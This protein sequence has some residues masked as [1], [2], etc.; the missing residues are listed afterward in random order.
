MKGKTL[1][2]QLSSQTLFTLKIFVNQLVPKCY[3]H[4]QFSSASTYRQMTLFR[5]RETHG[6]RVIMAFYERT[7]PTWQKRKFL[8]EFV[9]V[10]LNKEAGEFRTRQKLANTSIHRILKS[11]YFKKM[12]IRT[13]SN[14]SRILLVKSTHQF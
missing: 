12:W 1:P 3:F 4:K 7:G 5:E 10:C 9:K 8:M 6:K 13:L 14:C 11:E 2:C